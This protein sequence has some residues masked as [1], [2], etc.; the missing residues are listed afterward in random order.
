MSTS[1]TVRWSPH[2]SATRQRFLRIN[3]REQLLA[4]YDVEL[5]V[6]AALLL[7]LCTLLTWLDRRGK[8]CAST[9]LP[10]IPRSLT[11]ECVGL[12]ARDVGPPR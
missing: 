2:A 4:L 6:G 8:M 5:M 1:Q 7:Q 3:A 10:A 9:R 12:R 11:S